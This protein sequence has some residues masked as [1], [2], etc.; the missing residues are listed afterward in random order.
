MAT[1]TYPGVYLQELQSAVHSITGVATSV[2][3]FVGYT[4]RGIDDRAQMITS[5]ADYERLFGGL[6]TDSEVSYA[7]QQ[8]FNNGGTQA[9][10]VRARRKG[11][12]DAQVVISGGAINSLLTFRALSSGQWANGDVIID[13]DTNGLNEPVAG[14]VDVAASTNVTGVATFFSSQ[15]AVG[16]YLVFASDA[17]QTPYQI[18]AIASDTSLTLATAYAGAPATTTATVT[19]DPL[20]F[21]LTITNL[22]D[23]T[24]EPFP[25]V[26]LNS[27]DSNYVE[28]VIND[29]DNG[30]E[31][32]EVTQ[33]NPA[34]TVA[35]PVS[36]VVGAPVTVFS[37]GDALGGH[38]ALAGTV[39]VT[40]FSSTVTGTGTSFTSSMIGQWLTFAS[41][42]NTPYQVGSVASPTSLTL[43]APYLGVT[44]AATTG[45]A[46]NSTANHDWGLSLSVS[47]PATAPPPLPITV[48]LL[49]NLSPIPQTMA[50][51]A[52]QLQRAINAALSV[53][54]RGASVQCSVYG[55]GSSQ[56]I[57]INASL[58]Q[59]PD[60]VLSFGPPAGGTLSD[61][62]TALGLNALT[63][64][65]VAHYAL[66][67]NN[68]SS[69]NGWQGD[70]FTSSP[71][72]DGTGLPSSAELIGDQG[73]FTGIY[74]LLKVDSF[75][76]LCIPEATRAA[77]VNSPLL[78]TTVNP[79]AIYSAAITLCDNARAFLLIDPPPFVNTI[80]SALDWKTNGLT[81][82]DPNGAAYFPRVRVPDALSNFQLRTFAPC[83]VVAGLYA[84]TDATRGVWKAPAGTTATLAGVQ[85]LVYKMSDIE[86]G[87]LNPL[88]LNCFRTFPIYGTVSWGARTLVGADAET[89]QWKYVPVRRTALFL[90]SSLYQ[91]LKWVVFEPNDEPLWS[92]IRLNVG[93]FMQN[94]FVQGFFQGSTPSQAY[95]VKCDSQTT[96][97]TDI[98]N[99]IVN[100]VV[101]FAPLKPAE[102]V[103]IKIEQLAGQTAS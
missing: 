6:A 36:G 13:V 103:I 70:Q 97:Q 81:V 57:R 75:N 78:D 24:V 66:G 43:S 12:A 45:T 4:A 32:V 62:H 77:A 21:N 10:V 56:A 39:D 33:V 30:S 19:E 68:G 47:S 85:S 99:G 7:V 54:L 76:I 96:T 91:G 93:A 87:E 53:Q 8:F 44:A 88:G 79:N 37:V 98:N 17:T 63:V 100:I 80:A 22:A 101:G 27:S 73:L 92:A 65:N 31:L 2:A 86:N 42:A 83:G 74:A 11:S 72:S 23:G 46:A 49:A 102:F 14:S 95:F 69:V 29:Y 59:M 5:F 90:E 16:D 89:S 40:Q 35:P 15:L 26:T 82:N 94:L 20:S 55:V 41:Q 3:A 64:Q 60:A 48:S 58:P 52:S 38:T 50:G 84:D 28:T 18:Q 25:N 1:P 51:L 71:G 34:P 67:T 9:W 61:A